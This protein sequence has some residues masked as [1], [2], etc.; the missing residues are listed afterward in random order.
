MFPLHCAMLRRNSAFIFVGARVY[1]LRPNPSNGGIHHAR[2]IRQNCGES[3]AHGKGATVGNRLPA[4]LSRTCV[5]PTS[6]TATVAIHSN[7]QDEPQ[8]RRPVSLTLTGT[9]AIRLATCLDRSVAASGAIT[10]T[11]SPCFPW[12]KLLSLAERLARVE[13]PASGGSSGRIEP[14]KVLEPFSDRGAGGGRSKAVSEV[15]RTVA[16]AWVGKQAVERRGRTGRRSG[17]GRQR[18]AGWPAESRRCAGSWRPLDWI[19]RG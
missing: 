4:W 17:P 13:R 16:R 1:L 15:L 10:S 19:W 2:N 3:I 14:S 5:L 12:R 7:A 9:P 6:T 11:V 18:A 8:S